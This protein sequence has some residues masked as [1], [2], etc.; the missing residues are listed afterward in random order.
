MKKKYHI[1]AILFDMDGVITNTMHDHYLAW[2][3]VLHDFGISVTYLDIY[4]REG[5][6]GL[7]SVSELFQKYD[8]PFTQK[9]GQTLLAQKEKYFKKIVRIRFITGART[10][11]K[12]L[13]QQQF[14][15]AL[16][17]GTSRDELHQILPDHIYNL[18][19]VIVTGNDVKKG[20]PD[21]EPYSKALKILNISSYDAIVIENA[22]LGIQSA[23]SAGLTCLAI[24]TSLPAIYLKEADFIFKSIKDLITKTEFILN[25]KT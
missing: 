5:Q 2:K 18:F 24:E 14:Q 8:R 21:P 13:K 3:H 23:K 9:I 10:F 25:E 17:T 6:Q 15:L 12:K 1:K 16:V 22:P 19:S 20:K 11:L 7:Q 4:S